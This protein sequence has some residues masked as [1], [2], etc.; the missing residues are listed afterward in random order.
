MK[1][2]ILLSRVLLAV[3][4]LL[5]SQSLLA[6]GVTTSGMNGKVADENGAELPGATVIA[7]HAPTGSKYGSVTDV[8]GFYRIPNMK[9]GGPYN[10]T[11]S[12]VGFENFEQ[13]G[14]YLTL[15]QTYKLDATL[16]SGATELQEVIVSAA[17]GEIFDGNRNG[18]ETSISQREITS[19]PNASRSLNDFTRLTP[20]TTFT[21]TGGLSIAGTNNRYNSIFIDGAMS[22][23]VFGLASNG[24][25]GGQLNGLSLISIDAMEQIQVAVSPYDVTQS[26]FTGGS[27]SAVTRSGTNE[28]EGSAYYF[29]RNQSL[30]GKTPGFLEVDGEDREKLD[31]FTAKTYGARLGGPIIKDKLFFFINAEIQ[32]DETPQPFDFGTYS[33]GVSEADVLALVSQLNAYGYD[34]GSYEDVVQRLEAEKFLV[35]FDWNI[36]DKHKLT[37]RHSYN[38]GENFS[39]SNSSS[40]RIRFANSGVFFPSKTHSSA[41]EL[42]SN[43]GDKSNKLVIGRTSVKDNRD[44]LGA[45]FPYVDI[46]SGDIEAGSEQFS[47]ANLLEQEIWTLTDNF[48]LYKGR[49]T[50]TFGTHNEFY[51]INNVFIRQNFGSYRFADIAGFLANTPTQFD[52]SYSLIDNVTGDGTSAA[53]AFKAMQIGFYVQDE[54]QV[55][56]QLRLTGGLRVDIPFFSED[57]AATVDWATTKAAIEGFGYDLKGAES[58]QAPGAQLLIAPRLGF[59]YDVNGDQTTQLRGGL[60]IFTS[61]IPFVWPGGM[62][63]NNGVSVG[64]TR[65]FAGLTFEPNPNNQ[66]TLG[67]FGGTDATPQGQLDLFASDFKYPQ[68]FRM[69]AAVDQ[70][71]PWGMIGSVEF[72]YTKT[73]NN[74]FYENVNLK[75]SVENFGGTPDTRPIFDRGDEIDS[76]YTRILL[77]SNTSKGHTAN[78]TV[79]L[80]KPWENGFTAGLSYNFGTATSIFEGTSSQNSSQW[81][82]VYSVTGRNNAQVGR[83]D[84]D[85]GHRFML[86]ASYRK[87]YAGFA[88]STVSFFLNAQSG[89]PFSYT[90]DSDISN[91]DSRERALMF[92]PA[93]AAQIVFD[94]TDRTAAEQ[95][96]DLDAYIQND[97]YLKNRRGRY[98]EKNEARTPFTAVMD[99]K[100][101]QEF[102]LELAD[103]K[104]N[105]LQVT[106]DIFNFGNLINKDWGRRYG[107]PN[108]DETSVELLNYEGNITN[109]SGETVPTFSFP[110]GINEKQDILTKDDSGLISSRWQMQLGVRYIFGK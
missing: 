15:G 78:F 64:G 87:E 32:R 77:G 61:R 47:T 8:N 46:S 93:S 39:P 72:I 26:G 80:T 17:E 12:F 9:A 75:P 3:S 107:V 45:N 85:A 59:N 41:L 31:D 66:P 79:S 88:A 67:S 76:R 34:P 11:I 105:T 73:I 43:F 106:F 69:S 48:N 57:P 71:L 4:L 35:K 56:D 86:N 90:Y 81:R 58:G 19:M 37:A 30:A 5:A 54:I 40:S 24:Q 25:N 13:Q 70:K 82:G 22:N 91:E 29:I 65:Q 96:A 27:I 44:P 74:I 16:A 14:V 55:N 18:A 38:N 89:S 21:A 52:R 95:W 36:N 68:V 7:I 103:G 104:R 94:E 10:L 109:S 84:F 108:G 62:Y 23:D 28:F 51:D 20:Q 1:Q 6:Q 63:N 33:G 42:N 97:D 99:V 100:F 50:L 101:M 83:S 102:Y 49:H 110:D 2:K 53:A 60:G 92:V 98:A